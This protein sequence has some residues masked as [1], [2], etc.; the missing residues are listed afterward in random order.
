MRQVFS[1]YP[2]IEPP[3]P[4]PLQAAIRQRGTLFEVE[5]GNILKMP[6]ELHHFYMI[7]EGVCGYFVAGQVFGHPRIMST[8]LP[9]RTVADISVSVGRPC[10]I[11]TRA[12]TPVKAWAVP[13]SFF[14]E[15]VYKDPEILRMHYQLTVMKHESTVEGMI[16]NFTLPPELRLRVLFQLLIAADL[17]G[18]PHE[19]V[20]PGLWYRL[21]YR[22][23]AQTI[24]MIVNLTRSNV[25]RQL[26][27]WREAG[28]ARKEG[29]DWELA[30]VLF[31]NIY[32]WREE[33]DR[34]QIRPVEY[35]VELDTDE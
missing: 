6:G 16:A 35:D 20:K 14:D 34:G 1:T 33:L 5:S 11:E 7:E 8:L 28:L 26:N 31:E 3:A 24:G 29:I 17:Q 10:N 12:L 15:V 9:G 19:V 32:D 25:S 4:A 27:S 22:L 18:E 23:T 13:A 21:P 30:G 2:Y